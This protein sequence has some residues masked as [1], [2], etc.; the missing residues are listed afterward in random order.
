MCP[1]AAVSGVALE[2]S[3]LPLADLHLSGTA[4]LALNSKMSFDSEV[5]QV[6]LARGLG[7]IPG[8]LPA[9]GQ[10]CPKDPPDPCWLAGHGEASWLH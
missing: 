10:G 7:L 1:R 6:M 2:L 8:F 4:H 9:G 3:T 5:R